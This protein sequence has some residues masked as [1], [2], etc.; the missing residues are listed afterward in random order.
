MNRTIEKLVFVFIILLSSNTYAQVSGIHSENKT[1]LEKIYLTV[2]EESVDYFDSLWV[3]D[4]NILNSGFFNFAMYNDWLDGNLIRDGEIIENYNYSSVI[5]IPGNGMIL[6][7]YAVLLTETEKPTFGR[8]GLPRTELIERIIK[9]IRWISLTSAYV[10]SDY[11]YLPNTPTDLLDG[12]KWKRRDGRRADI[13]GYLTLAVAIADQYIDQETKDLFTKVAVGGI[14]KSRTIRNWQFGE[15]GNHDQVKHDLSS[16]YGAAFFFGNEKEKQKLHE[17]LIPAGIDL[18]GTHHDKAN[19]TIVEGKSIYQWSKGW[20]LYEDYSSDHHGFAS[21]W[22]G[23]E[24]IFEAR[25]FVDLI[26]KISKRQIPETFNYPGNGFEGVLEWIKDLT[27]KNGG[28]I[29]PHGVEYDSYYGAGLLAFCYGATVIQ[30]D[31]SS[32]LE[33]QAAKLMLEHTRSVRKYDY[34]RG[35]WAKA[36]LAFLMHKYYKSDPTQLDIPSTLKSLEGTF[37]YKDQQN[38]IHRSNNKTVSF[39]WGSLSSAKNNGEGFCGIV[40]P[41][42]TSSNSEDLY[43]YSHPNSL[44]GKVETFSFSQSMKPANL[45]KSIKWLIVEI[46]IYSSQLST[47]LNMRLRYIIIFVLLLSGYVVIIYFKKVFSNLTSDQKRRHVLSISF[48]IAAPL[49]SFAWI[50]IEHEVPNDKILETTYNYDI[51]DDCFSST[52]LLQMRDVNRYCSIFSFNNGPTIFLNQFYATSSSRVSWSGISQY[53]FKKR[54]AEDNLIYTFQDGS[55]LLSSE[56]ESISNWWNLDNQLGVITI[57]GNGKIQNGWGIGFNWARTDSYKDKYDSVSVSKLENFSMDPGETF[58]IGTV[59]YTY[60]TDDFIMSNRSKAIDISDK[61]PDGWFGLIAPF[62][63]KDPSRII[64]ISNFRNKQEETFLEVE[65]QYGAPVFNRTTHI[66]KKIAG[67]NIR[68][69]KLDAYSEKLSWYVEVLSGIEINAKKIDKNSIRIEPINSSQN[70]ISIRYAGDYKGEIQFENLNGSIVYTVDA[71]K[72]AFPSKEIWELKEPIIVRLANDF[73]EDY[74]APSVIIDE[75]F[76][77]DEKTIVFVKASDQ[78]GIKNVK[79]FCDGVEIGTI[80]NSPYKWTID[81]S[82][83]WHTF[84]AIATDDSKNNN[85]RK[86]FIR[87]VEIKGK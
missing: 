8:I 64:A 35:S 57:G 27:L 3:D 80:E 2:L 82:P 32:N 28:L 70:T 55:S 36:A 86:S 6:L 46:E 81:L 59:I 7:A 34:H 77:I 78:S 52:G 14:Q 26:T 87:T 43:I 44:T 66:K 75:I 58:E 21:V 17:L 13:I 61:L 10:N 83:G 47:F 30:D 33:F 49:I 31:V 15:G 84:I 69:P 29:H 42:N 40:V 24:I 60:Q 63:E 23:S 9:S 4:P 16:T 5:T 67:V 25:I 19:T 76:E 45:K 54:G 48:L 18:V 22:Y 74:L 11:S 71:S 51:S 50:I 68:V 12:K 41:Q 37:Y 65:F 79:L 20:N 73:T 1:K 85:I 56:A 39:S 38:I 72:L 53:I 62:S